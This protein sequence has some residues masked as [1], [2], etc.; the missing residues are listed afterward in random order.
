MSSFSSS[1]SSNASSDA[2]I[3]QLASAT[4]GSTGLPYAVWR[5]LM[6]TFLMRQGIEERDYSKEIPDWK[7]LVAA[8]ASDA[9]EEERAA[10]ALVLGKSVPMKSEEPFSGLSGGDKKGTDGPMSQHMKAKKFVADVISRSRKAFGFLHAAL[11]SDLRQLMND[12]DQ[13]YAYGI[14]SRLEKKYRSTEQDSVL[15]LWTTFANLE[16][17]P[18]ESFEAYKARV[19]SVKELLEHAKQDVPSGLYAAILIWKLQPTYAQ[20]VLALRTGEKVKDP[21]KV[22]W[23]F[24]GDTMSTFER[25]QMKLTSP[26]SGS[27]RALAMRGRPSSSKKNA[28]HASSRFDRSRVKCFRCGEHGHFA[29]EC[30]KVKRGGVQPGKKRG[31][32]ARS[33]SDSSDDEDREG[34]PRAGKV[35][36]VRKS[37]YYSALSSDDDDGNEEENDVP[38]ASSR[39]GAMGHAYLA[40]VL[41]GMESSARPLKRLKRPGEFKSP[42][43]ANPP[44]SLTKKKDEAP[45]KRPVQ[46]TRAKREPTSTKSLDE[47]LRTT[48]RAVDSGATVNVTGNKDCLVNVRRC[49]PMPIKMADQTIISAVYKG[50]MPMRIPVD[51]KPDKVVN[52]AIKDV[53]YHER[54]DSNL[55]SWDRM[56]VSGWHLHSTPEGTYLITPGGKRVKASTRGRLTLLEDAGPERAL[57]LRMGRVVCSTV[58]E[59]V[60]LHQRIGHASWTR[61]M[62]MCRSGKVSGVGDV[63]GMSSNELS[64]AE[65]EIKNCT[66]CCQGKQPRNALGHRGLD[67]GSEPGEVLHMDSMYAT[68]CNPVTKK[69]Y[70][71][72]CLIVTDGF[73]EFRYVAVSDAMSDIKREMI[74]IIKTSTTISGRKPRLIVSDLGKEFDNGATARYC[75]NNGIKLQPTPARAKELNGVAEKSVDTVKNHVRTMLLAARVPD[76]MGWKYALQ[77][78]VYLW[79]RTHIGKA[80]SKTPY[81][82]MFKREPSIMHVG[83]FGCDAFVHMDRSQ[84]ETTFSPKGEPGI[85]LGHDS[86]VNC[87]TVLMLHTGKILRVKDVI[88]RE[89]S[90]SHMKAELKGDRESVASMDI[91]DLFPPTEDDVDAESDDD[92]DGDGGDALKT[93]DDSEVDDHDDT[94]Y[95]VSAI[96]DKRLRSDGGCDYSVKWKGYSSTTWEPADVIRLDAPAAVKAYEEFVAKRSSARVTRSA[97]RRSNM[98]SGQNVQS[99]SS[100]DDDDDGDDEKSSLAAVRYAAAKC[101]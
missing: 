53:Y 6:Q 32:A 48:A 92:D 25:D 24:V 84:R 86:R 31:E 30:S 13:G 91:A 73:T 8:V 29:K 96:V 57:A 15:E 70:Y 81:E 76:R 71:Q 49:M 52:I 77:H 54:I 90:F 66:A 78:H 59:L 101:L 60:M 69:K 43:V 39:R 99:S 27:D 55:L 21:T 100:S 40:R 82:M 26:E 34:K 64:K 12:V 20:A 65:E 17:E 41:A 51:G 42:A 33:S 88:F 72:Y 10:M 7:K 9:E 85:Y 98:V 79:N 11:P 80:T 44:S 67:K 68:M 61:M 18:N 45:V 28:D 16:Q 4:G 38:S 2:K 83:V 58:D 74:E 50:D 22:D 47:A 14:W 1:S 36:A 62:R 97:A 95:E 94:R 46:P 93:I 23:S 37:N 75:A 3:P 19:D 35:N 89:G 87:A 63:S 56:R 5:P